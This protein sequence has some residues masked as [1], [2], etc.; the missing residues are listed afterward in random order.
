MIVFQTHNESVIKKILQDPII[1][2]AI[3][4]DN[5]SADDL[6]INRYD[7]FIIGVNDSGLIGLV[8][9]E[10][11]G[12][13]HVHVLPK[14]RKYSKEFGNRCLEWIWANTEHEHIY[15]S[16]PVIFP[17]VLAFVEFLGFK[18]LKTIIEDWRKNGMRHDSIIMTLERP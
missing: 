7:T 16:I 15:C 11:N 4:E 3:S 1:F 6:K 8:I 13:C 18:K 14:M 9:I 2:D 5:T 10:N 17:N 12:Y